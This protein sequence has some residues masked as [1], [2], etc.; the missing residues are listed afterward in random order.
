MVSPRRALLH[1][2]ML[3]V[4]IVMAVLSSS[5]IIKPASEGA[6]VYEAESPY[7]YIQ[8]VQQGDEM[9]LELNEGHAIHSVYSP[10]HILTGGPWDYF[11]LAPFFNETFF[12]SDVHSVALLGLGAGTA[13]R[14]CDAAFGSQVSIDGVEI[15]PEIIKVG[16]EY[17]DM[18]EPNLTTIAQD[19][20]YFLQTTSKKYDLIAVDAYRQPYIPFHLTTREFFGEVRQHL[21]P[22]G[23]VV[24]NVGHTISDTRLLD[25]IASTMKA[26]YPNVYVID[27]EVG[28][29][30]L[31]VGTNSPSEM[32][33]FARNTQYMQSPVLLQV[34]NDALTTGN[35][36]EVNVSTEVYTDDHAPVEQLIDQ[37]IFS[38]AAGAR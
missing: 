3:V 16:R 13:A 11:M 35:I 1:S 38:Y 21:T 26:V 22:R 14:Q 7:N 23:A 37:M 5:G 24:I 2:P 6:L 34:A 32:T 28:M 10:S 29:N 33:D 19:A 9:L 8:V 20:R 4:V 25:V 27:T 30:S 17:F 12:E 15:D 18:N 31:V 36:R